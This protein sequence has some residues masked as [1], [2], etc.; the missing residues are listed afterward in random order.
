MSV[1]ME[2]RERSG[3]KTEKKR[4]EC[5]KGREIVLNIARDLQYH[6]FIGFW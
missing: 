6:N 4:S 2:G 5:K 3:C 1:C